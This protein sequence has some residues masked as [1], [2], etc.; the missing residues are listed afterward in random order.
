MKRQWIIAAVYIIIAA[1]YTAVSLILVTERTALFWAGLVFFL[2]ADAAAGIITV[3]VSSKRSSVFP[4][5]LSFVVFSV[6]YIIAVFV[7]NI[8]FCYLFKA[9]VRIFTSIQLMLL[10][11]YAIIMLLLLLVKKTIEKNRDMRTE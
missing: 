1:L 7:M 8:V 3:A 6:I 2:I 10:A 5:E 4:M 9:S 11:I